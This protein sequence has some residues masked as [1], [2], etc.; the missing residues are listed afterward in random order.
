[1][2]KKILSLA[3]VY[4]LL[5]T[6]TS[7]AAIALNGSAGDFSYEAAPATNKTASYTVG[8]GSNL[9]L[10]I[11]IVGYACSSLEVQVSGVTYNSVAMTRGGHSTRDTGGGCWVYAETWYLLNPATGFNTISVTLDSGADGIFW[12]AQAL[13][14]VKQS[15]QP[16]ATAT[17]SAVTSGSP[18][19]TSVT[20]VAANS[21]VFDAL[22][23]ANITPTGYSA[24][25]TALGGGNSGSYKITTT[26]GANSMGWTFTGGPGDIAHAV[27]SLS[28]DTGAT[29]ATNSNFFRLVR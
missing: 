16:D 23:Y 12:T 10:E 8:G 4:F 22:A 1:M 26:A 13:V 19:T 18:F 27:L 28:P 14:G 11:S 29:P 17:Q 6:T 2:K 7:Y 15:A 25:Q 3:L 21:W 5:N 24:G 20:T 9:A